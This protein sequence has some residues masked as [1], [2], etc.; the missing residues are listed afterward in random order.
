MHQYDFDDLMHHSSLSIANAL[1][2]LQ[3]CTNNTMMPKWPR[4]RIKSP[5]SQLFTQPFIQGADQRK[6]QNSVSQAFVQ[7]IHRWSVNS[8]HNGA[9]TRKM[10]PFDDVIINHRFHGGY[11]DYILRKTNT[12]RTFLCF[13]KLGSRLFYISMAQ[14]KTALA[15][16][17]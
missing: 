17:R 10:F 2:I 12:V 1:D 16:A 15:Q 5:A 3:P 13:V 8:P 6:L 4:R 11:W 9:V 7:G 14:C